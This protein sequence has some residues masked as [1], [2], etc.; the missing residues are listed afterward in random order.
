MTTPNMTGVS[1]ALRPTDLEETL[2]FHESLAEPIIVL[3]PPGVGKSEIVRQVSAKA[4][5][6]VVY[7]DLSSADP[8]DVGGIPFP[9]RLEDGTLIVERAVFKKFVGDKP[10][11][12]FVDET[13]QGSPAVMNSVAPLFLEKRL[14]DFFLPE[15]TW[16][17][18]ASNRQQDRAGTSRPPS[19]L[20]NR[21]TIV[22]TAFHVDDLR[23]HWID[24]EMPD[25]LLGFAKYAPD[26][27]FDFDPNRF[28][29]ATPR[30]WTWIGENFNDLM[31]LSPMSRMAI[32]GGRV[33]EG[34]AAKFM[35]FCKVFDALPSID[36]AL[37]N[38]GT[39]PIPEPLDIR[40]A[41]AVAISA[42]MT[43]DNIDRLCKIEERM[44]R[45]IGVMMMNDAKRRNK[46]IT[47]TKAFRDWA[48]R[49]ASVMM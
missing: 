24:N 15:G 23:M 8:T 49:N 47:S 1:A 37:M 35:G 16:I 46:N 40:Y 31:H 45:N 38:P 10:M 2:R 26:S 20:P 32:I 17:V 42:C 13:F 9:L 41:F 22:E 19:H 39:I 43:P 14:G 11:T 3:G 7:L 21:V 25:Q 12:I 28:V 27:I 18:G 4:D 33:G 6:T 5:R 29:N 36:E 30:Q 34:N 48:V 44:P